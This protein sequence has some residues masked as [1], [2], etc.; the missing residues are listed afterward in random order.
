[1][2]EQDIQSLQHYG[3]SQQEAHFLALAAPQ[4]GYFTRRQF[5][6]FLGQ[7]RGDNAQRFVDK[8]LT[9]RHAQFERY[10]GNQLVYHIRAKGIY[11]RLGQA[12]NRNRRD[13]APFTIKRKLM[14]LDFVL[15]HRDCPYFASE[16][17]K[18]AYFTIDREIDINLLPS[19]RYQAHETNQCPERFFVEKFP[20]FLDSG[21]SPV[22]HFLYI[23]EGARSIQ[24]FHTFM[25][26]YWPLLQG[27]GSFEVIYAAA[28][29][30]LFADAERLFLKTTGAAARLR[31]FDDSE[32][33]LAYFETRRKIE[34][35]DYRGIDS[36]RIVQFRAE[37]QTFAG[38][39]YEE[40]Y[41]VWLE[42]GRAAL[43]KRHGVACDARFQTY[44]LPED[45][46]IFG[47]LSHAA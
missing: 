8:L 12:D 3:Y 24:G 17:E 25:R 6:G 26:Q 29:H 4:S 32:T 35:R 46:Q 45:Y 36:Q 42:G 37:K 15:A 9:R 20:I 43:S 34:S 40:L 19:R 21:A 33:M 10:Q 30:E 44:L 23:D 22:P 1:M 31:L 47:R 7:E 41:R 28:G 16:R 38:D 2:L 14:A 27:L 39:Q 11:R 13:K 18:V 5:N